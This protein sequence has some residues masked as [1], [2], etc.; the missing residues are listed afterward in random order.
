MGGIVF[1]L[2]ADYFVRGYDRFNEAGCRGLLLSPTGKYTK[3]PPFLFPDRKNLSPS[4][5]LKT[6]TLVR[7]HIT[8]S[9]FLMCIETQPFD[10]LS[11]LPSSGSLPFLMVLVLLDRNPRPSCG[12]LGTSQQECWRALPS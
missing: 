7:V 6:A 1:E 8:V 12:E 11:E 5:F 2:P 4:S 3:F 9:F 10:R